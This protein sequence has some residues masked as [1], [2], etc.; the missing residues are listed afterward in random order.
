MKKFFLVV[1]TIILVFAIFIYFIFTYGTEWL[2]G[3]VADVIPYEV[4]KSIGETTLQSMEVQSF[5]PSSLPIFTQHNIKKQF[6]KIFQ[7]DIYDVHLLFRN[8]S[9]PI[10]FALA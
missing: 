5:E 9:Y 1:I 2:S 4:E 10:A 7:E 6:Y 3:V 8:A